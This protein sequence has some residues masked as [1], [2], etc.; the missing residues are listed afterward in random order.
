MTSWREDAT[1]Q[2]QDD[3]DALLT[4]GLGFAQ[5]LLEK[6]GEFF[7]FAVGIS[8]EGDAELIAAVPEGAGEQPDSLE[9]I[10]E[11][12]RALGEART[13]LRAGAIVSD[14]LANGSDAIRVE[15]EHAEGIAIAALLPYGT[16]RLG[17]KLRYGDLV[18]QDGAARIWT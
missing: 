1:Q 16:R 15:M 17:K 2:T 12:V 18:A 13:A 4:A 11:C 8:L 10:D 9:V 14:V 3:L 5:Q 6:H 7:P